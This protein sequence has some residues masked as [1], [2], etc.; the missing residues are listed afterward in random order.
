MSLSMVSWTLNKRGAFWLRIRPSVNNDS[1]PGRQDLLYF[2]PQATDTINYATPVDE[3][4][5]NVSEYVA[6]VTNA[7]NSADPTFAELA[8]II[9]DEK[10]LRM[11]ESAEE[12]RRLY[13]DL[14]HD[15]E[16]LT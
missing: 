16:A 10:N 6:D 15:I 2:L 8:Q 14:M 7:S 4:D 11:P 5:L 9:M 3:D 13:I 12:A 1:P